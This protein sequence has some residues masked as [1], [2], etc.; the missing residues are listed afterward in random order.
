[1]TKIGKYGQA[2]QFFKKFKM[3]YFEPFLYFFL[4]A[5]SLTEQKK[6]LE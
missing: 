5:L 2:M 3:Y 4:Q 6:V 1:M